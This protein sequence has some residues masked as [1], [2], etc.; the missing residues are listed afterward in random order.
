[1]NGTVEPRAPAV[2]AKLDGAAAALAAL[3]TEVA[4]LALAAA[5]NKPGAAGRLAAHR[6]KIEEAERRVGELRRAVTLA[7]QIDRRNDVDARAK[8]RSSQL[9][10]MIAHAKDRDTAVLEICEAAKAMAAAYQRY[11]QSTLKMLGVKPIGTAIPAMGMGPN[12]LCGSVIGN[13]ELLIAVELFRR[14]EDDADG[15]RYVVPLARPLSAT[16]A[17]PITTP[18]AIEMFRAAQAAILAD[19]QGQ[20][21]KIDAED[22]VATMRTAA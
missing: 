18:P 4:E 21:E 6:S 14:S 10:A 15:Q 9:E 17:S 2:I 3:D 22:M 12:A 1:M 11:S 5:E 19:I 7:V 20:V 16:N 8:I 13:L